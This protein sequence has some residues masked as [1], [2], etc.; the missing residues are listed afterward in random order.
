MYSHYQMFLPLISLL[1][2]SRQLIGE[3]LWERCQPSDVFEYKRCLPQMRG[4]VVVWR[5]LLHYILG[6]WL[7]LSLLRWH[8][9]GL[10]R[11]LRWISNL[12]NLILFLHG[13]LSVFN[14]AGVDIFYY[15]LPRFVLS[16]LKYYGYIFVQSIPKSP[17]KVL[18][19]REVY[20]FNQ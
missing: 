19:A 13:V 11:A 7:Q 16:I 17:K 10:W 2:T 3:Q 14:V 20:I 4:I 9:W 8:R 5:S 12:T 15:C 1:S 6:I 18:N